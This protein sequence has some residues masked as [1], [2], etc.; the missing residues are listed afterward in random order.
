MARNFYKVARFFSTITTLSP[1]V[2]VLPSEVKIHQMLL[3]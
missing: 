1:A 3:W 2:P